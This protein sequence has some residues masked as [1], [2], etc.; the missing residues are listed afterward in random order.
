MKLLPDRP[1]KSHRILLAEDHFILREA[2]RDLL[3]GQPDFEVVGEAGDGAEAVRLAKRLQPR[4]VLMD[5][6]LPKL[7][8]VEATQAI[9][10]ACPQVCVVAFTAHESPFVLDQMR[11]AGARGYVC[12]TAPPET[13]LFAI[14]RVVGGGVYFDPELMSEAVG[15]FLADPRP[16]TD[17]SARETQVLRLLAQGYLAKEVA[18]KLKV[19][20]KSVE[21]YKARLMVKLGVNSRVELMHYAQLKYRTDRP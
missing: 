3:N 18:E 4:L 1:A 11:Q 10:K 20:T 9:M 2:V 8:G 19:S 6:S 7:D 5:I 17:L 21:T 12:K 15:K 13:I 16:V 14:R